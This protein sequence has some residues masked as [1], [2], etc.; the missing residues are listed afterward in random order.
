VEQQAERQAAAAPPQPAAPAPAPEPPDPHV[1]PP[2]DAPPAP[3]PVA[4]TVRRPRGEVGGGPFLSAG[5][6]PFTWG[7]AV[8]GASI[9]PSFAHNRG[10]VSLG[11]DLS[12]SVPVT[13]NYFQTQLISLSPLVCLHGDLPPRGNVTWGGLVCP[14]GALG[15]LHASARGTTSS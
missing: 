6:P 1:L 7:F 4:P 2:P 14:L 9:T 10:R 11:L 15:L 12:A 5:G 8:H 13:R 3:P